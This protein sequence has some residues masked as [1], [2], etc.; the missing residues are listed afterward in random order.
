MSRHGSKIGKRFKIAIIIAGVLAAVIVTLFALNYWF[1]S[2]TSLNKCRGC[3]SQ[4]KYAT[5][6]LGQARAT[7]IAKIGPPEAPGRVSSSS[8]LPPQ[9]V[10]G[11]RASAR[12]Q[13]WTPQGRRASD[14]E[15][16]WGREGRPRTQLGAPGGERRR[17]RHHAVAVLCCL[18]VLPGCP[19]LD[20]DREMRYA[21][22]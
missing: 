22:P 6:R 3:I 11:R 20:A 21:Q 9:S 14:G 16:P 1:L 18:L 19:R 2:G 12:G 13:A 15:Q 10:Q 8:G 5:A 17:S 4:T 7:I